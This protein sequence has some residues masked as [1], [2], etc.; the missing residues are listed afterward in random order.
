MLTLHRPPTESS[1]STD[2]IG[3]APWI[4]TTPPGPNASQAVARDR[5]VMSPS[6]TRPYPLVVRRA[7]GSIVEDVDENRFLD[8]TAGLAVCSTGHCHPQVVQAI[9]RQAR[10]L[11]HIC[12]SDFYYESMIALAE[13]LAQITPGAG[14]KRVLF[15][16]SGAETVEAAIKLSRHYT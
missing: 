2:W 5:R 7:Q 13:K 16:N 9:E 3:P 14:A 15:T 12:G 4:T 10:Q 6:Y 1:V 8:F 11:I